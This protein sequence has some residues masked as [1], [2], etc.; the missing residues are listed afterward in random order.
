MHTND[1]T[2]HT[3]NMHAMPACALRD[4]R[5]FA[6]FPGDIH[7]PGPPHH[8]PVAKTEPG[9][10]MRYVRAR[11]FTQPPLRVVPSELKVHVAE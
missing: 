3:A 10:S 7:L 2:L 6:I 11:H 5:L 9:V 1:A 4:H 8:A